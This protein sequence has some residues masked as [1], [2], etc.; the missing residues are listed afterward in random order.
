MSQNIYLINIHSFA[1]AGDAA[2]TLATIQQLERNFPGC[3]VTLQVDDLENYQEAYHAVVSIYRWVRGSHVGGNPKWN[4]WNLIRLLPSTLIP[5]FTYRLIRRPCF[6]L[7]PVSL[8]PALKAYFDA[9]LIVSKPGGF[10]YS[11]GLGVTLIIA[12]YVMALGIFSGKPVYLYPQSIGPLKYKWECFLIRWLAMK[13]RIFMVREKI[14]LDQL[15][16]CGVKQEQVRLIPDTAF[17]FQTGVDAGEWFQNHGFRTGNVPLMG[18]T[19]I[20]WDA[21]NK[22]FSDQ[23]KYEL[24]MGALAR[25]FILKYRG[26]VVIFTQVWGPSESQ[27]DRPAAQRVAKLLADLQECILLLDEPLSPSLLKSLYAHMDLFTGTRMHSNIFA[28]SQ[29]IPVIAIGYYHK[30]QGIMRMLGLQDWVVEINHIE[31]N[32][33]LFLLDQLWENRLALKE[34]ISIKVQE[35]IQQARQAGNWVAEDFEKTRK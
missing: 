10:L 13:T 2:L 5:V 12:I 32:N 16:K 34:S 31:K 18:M 14:S 25:E 8:H 26:K 9:D 6:W 4:K 11:S 1:N 20:Q 35:L 7:T 23:A 30:T 28:L 22:D 3:D 24:M 17:D 33:L 19:V 15:E 21:Q 27:D 29:G